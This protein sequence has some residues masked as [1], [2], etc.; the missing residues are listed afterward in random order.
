MRFRPNIGQEL[1]KPIRR[2]ACQPLQDVF[3][4]RERIDVV[5]LAARH[6]AI[7]RSQPSCRI[8]LFRRVG[9]G[10]PTGDRGNE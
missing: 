10:I 9:D 3:Q 6:Q 4:V 7:Q 8:C 5:T 1:A 2:V